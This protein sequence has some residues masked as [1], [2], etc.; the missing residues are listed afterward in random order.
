MAIRGLL[1]SSR[2]QAISITRKQARL[3]HIRESEQLLREPLESQSHPTVRRHAVTEGFEIS[4]DVARIQPAPAEALD[5]LI[6][7]VNSLPTGA[8]LNAVEEQVERA[9]ARWIRFHRH[10]VNRP[11]I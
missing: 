7:P 4:V 6:V 1:L 2:C 9:R 10:R 11:T 8:D 3:L 5:E